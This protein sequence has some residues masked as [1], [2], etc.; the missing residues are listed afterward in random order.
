M[1]YWFFPGVYPRPEKKTI[2]NTFRTTVLWMKKLNSRKELKKKAVIAEMLV[3]FLLLTLSLVVDPVFPLGL[4]EI[5][6]TQ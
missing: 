2:T 4:D 5:D 3:A 6:R 1:N